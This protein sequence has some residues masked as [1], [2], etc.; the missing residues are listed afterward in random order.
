MAKDFADSSRF[1]TA[2]SDA[3]DIPRTLYERAVNRHR[4]VGEWLCRPASRLATLRPEV[5]P[6]GSFRYGTVTQ[7]IN[8]GAEYDLDHVVVLHGLTTRDMSQKT[9]KD[10]FGVELLE[11]ATT[12]RMKPPTEHNRCWRLHYRDEA[13]FHL[14]SLPC[15]PAPADFR[16][17]LS[18]GGVD[19]D[20]ATRAVSITDKRRPDFETT[21]ADWLTSNPRGFARW[22][23]NRAALG[24]SPQLSTE[25]RATVEDVPAYEWKT[26]LQRSIQILKRHRDLMFKNDS[27]FA[28]ISMIV[29]NLS[30]SAYGGELDL[31][32]ALSGILK[33]MPAYVR[34]TLPRVPNPTHPREDYADRW[35]RDQRYEANFWGW[36]RQ[37]VVDVDHLS[38]EPSATGFKRAFGIELALSS[39]A[40]GAPA[41]ILG[42]LRDTSEPVRITNAPKPWAL[43]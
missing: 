17:Q 23:E 28:P 22:F 34:K 42:G 27:E 43:K 10:I 11:Y 25:F 14:D 7:P 24:R 4:S 1:W 15:I 2:L 5:R 20:L 33:G 38:A 18:R 31:S 39:L 6:Q 8:P 35:R 13:E 32:I 41:V 3:L 21:S 26:P 37:A 29:T 19:S 30:A 40:V 16:D 9:L 12:H 36:Y